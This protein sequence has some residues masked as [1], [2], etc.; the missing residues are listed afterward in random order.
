MKVAVYVPGDCVVGEWDFKVKTQL[1]DK[2][3]ED[4]VYTH[5]TYFILLFNPW[6]KGGQGEWE[7]GNKKDIDLVS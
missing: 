6:S 7:G 5:P 1:L 2:V 4:Y 3:N